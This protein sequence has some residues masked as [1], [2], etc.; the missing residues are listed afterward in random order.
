M[1]CLALR[2]PNTYRQLCYCYT[3]FA[4]PQSQKQFR[5]LPKRWTAAKKLLWFAV[6]EAE[7]YMKDV[8][9][10]VGEYAAKKFEVARNLLPELHRGLQRLQKEREQEK[11]TASESNAKH[12]PNCPKKWTAAQSIDSVFLVVL[13]F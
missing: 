11:E 13:L 12:N 6:L 1:I 2:S 4:A 9:H 5:F 10:D 8:Q 7:R 3:V